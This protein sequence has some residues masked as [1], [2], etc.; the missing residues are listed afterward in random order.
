MINSTFDNL[1]LV[2]PNEAL[3]HPSQTNLVEEPLDFWGIEFSPIFAFLKRIFLLPLRPHLLA[4][5]FP[6]SETLSLVILINM[7]KS[8]N[9][10]GEYG[11]QAMLR[12][13]SVNWNSF[14]SSLQRRIPLHC[15]TTLVQITD[16]LGCSGLGINR[17]FPRFTQYWHPFPVLEGI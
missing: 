15:M 14:F 11:C 8:H 2:S 12:Q 10:E 16:I 7:V 17:E 6:S 1:F 3:T 4:R 9:R 13:E 5:A